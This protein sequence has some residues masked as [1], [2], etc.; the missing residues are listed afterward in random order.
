MRALRARLPNENFI[1]LG[2][3][4]RLPYGTKSADTVTRYAVQAAR[5]LIA[6]DIK[7]LV[8]ACNTASAVALRRLQQTWLPG[9]RRE[10]GRPVN[11]LGLIVPTIEAVTG[12]PWEHEAERRGD[13]IEKLDVVG[14]FCTNAT[15]NSR[16]YEI[17][18][19]KRRQDI[20]VF[21]EACSGLVA[22]IE[23]D[24]PRED[25]A[26]VIQAHAVALKTRIGRWP[27][28]AILGCTHRRPVPRGPAGRHAADPPA[29]RHRRRARPL[30]RAP[31]RVR[32]GRR[33]RAPLADHGGGGAAVGPG[34]DLLG[35]A[36]EVR[37]GVRRRSRRNHLG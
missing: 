29:D 28:R 10:L 31:S 1:Y 24:A 35:R 8:V 34:G 6:R 5:A 36:R 4:A 32:P 37:G 15:F 25:M 19:D 20:A 13:K 11:V 21:S 27:D 17:E 7:M 16:V 12:M 33:R 26:A 14:V 18:I 3:T 22:M 9:L 30:P 23:A 2:D